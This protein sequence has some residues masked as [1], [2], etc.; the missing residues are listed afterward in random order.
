MYTTTSS[1]K[2]WL[3]EERGAGG[4]EWGQGKADG[5][6]HEGCVALAATT[7][8]TELGTK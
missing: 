6:L 2:Q 4:G 3:E 8:T 7:T 1:Y 5:N